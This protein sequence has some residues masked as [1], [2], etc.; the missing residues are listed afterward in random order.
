MFWVSTD[1]F[2]SFCWFYGYSTFFS[3]RNILFQIFSKSPIDQAPQNDR[4]YV[5]NQKSVMMPLPY[6]FVGDTDVYSLSL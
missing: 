1:I 6:F 3:N 4:K 2:R 5:Q